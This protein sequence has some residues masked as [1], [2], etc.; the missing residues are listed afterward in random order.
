MTDVV[1]LPVPANPERNKRLF[2]WALE[3]LKG[4]GLDHA[5]ALAKSTQELRSSA[6]NVES[7]QITLAIRAA[8]HSASAIWWTSG[9]RT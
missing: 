8:L 2:D 7:V 9:W 6:L 5:I 3:V 1:R 4:L